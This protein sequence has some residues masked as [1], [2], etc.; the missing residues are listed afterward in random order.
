MFGDVFI[1]IFLTAISEYDQVIDEDKTTN[2][3]K[4]SLTLFNTIL[5]YPFFMDKDVIVFL[6]KTDLLKEK[7]GKGISKVSE[8]FPEFEGKDDSVEEVQN[9]FKVMLDLQI[10]LSSISCQCLN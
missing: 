4:E 2:R 5:N 8:Y 3:I 10:H 7:I 9:F 1:L 6:N